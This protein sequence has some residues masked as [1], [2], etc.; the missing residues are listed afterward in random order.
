[1]KIVC[2]AAGDI[3]CGAGDDW[4]VACIIEQMCTCYYIIHTDVLMYTTDKAY[5]TCIVDILVVVVVIVDSC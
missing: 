1:M 2:V 3:L 4:F 5:N